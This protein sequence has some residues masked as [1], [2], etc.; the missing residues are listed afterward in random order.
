MNN[1]QKEPLWEKERQMQYSTVFIQIRKNTEGLELWG[2]I[3]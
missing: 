3:S 2:L 1:E